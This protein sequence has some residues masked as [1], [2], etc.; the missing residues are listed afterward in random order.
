MSDIQFEYHEFSWLVA[1]AELALALFI[2]VAVVW[3]IRR[4]LR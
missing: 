3:F 1:A 2:V 4:K